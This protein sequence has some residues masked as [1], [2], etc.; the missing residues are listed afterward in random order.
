M[1]SYLIIVIIVLII[2][3][4][5]YYQNTQNDTTLYL[6]RDQTTP[7]NRLQAATI[8][9]KAAITNS[10][11]AKYYFAET[12]KF[13]IISSTSPKGKQF[14]EQYNLPSIPYMVKV[15]NGVEVDRFN[16]TSLGTAP[17]QAKI[18]ELIGFQE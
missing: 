7:S 8:Q 4:Y 10:K 9:Y 16:D 18:K 1:S 15:R 5:G 11:S 3:L 14:I 6:V 2:I 12:V 13:V 17:F